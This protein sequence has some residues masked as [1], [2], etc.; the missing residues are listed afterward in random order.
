MR[1]DLP[2]I[3]A[4]VFNRLAELERRQ[5]NRS[6]KGKVVEVNA[7]E[8]WARV[9]LN[10]DP[11]TGKPFL[12]PKIPWQMPAMGA[13][14]V[15]IP[16][17]VGQQVEV[18]SESGDLTDAVINNSLR[19]NANPQPDAN[20]GDGVITTGDTR[21]FFSGSEVRIKSPKIVL[22]GEVHLGA[23]GGEL[24]H[25]KGD[26]DSAGDIAVGSSTKVYAV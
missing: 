19:S 7:A 17:S 18:V 15:N 23:E 4:D 16:P 14:K 13:T 6:R 11:K 26:D 2:D 21:I 24:V 25:R 8:G 3:M 20:P 5:Q 22:E 10:K 9:E 1:T 12:S